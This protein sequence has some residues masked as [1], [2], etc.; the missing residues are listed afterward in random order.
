MK[1]EKLSPNMPTFDIEPS[2]I[3]SF[4][5]AKLNNYVGI[6][7]DEERMRQE[8]ILFIQNNPN[9][10]SRKLLTGHVNGSAWVVDSEMRMA[11]LTHHT[12]LDRW[13]QLGGHSDEDPNTLNVAQR[14][15]I[16]ESGLQSVLPI[17]QEIFDIDVHPIPEKGDEPGHL[18]YDIRF[19]F[20]ADPEEELVI[21]SESKDLQWVEIDAISA[22]NPSES[23]I[24]MVTKT[25]KLKDNDR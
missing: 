8:T 13:L 20:T 14:E 17:S 5:L 3:R 21:S 11:L 23:L 6:N 18:H 16:E 9:C 25:K 12:K 15:A 19:I 24:R 2:D 4:I 10:F 7:E 22:L 1:K